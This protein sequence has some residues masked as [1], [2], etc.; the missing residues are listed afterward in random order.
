MYAK[1]CIGRSANQYSCLAYTAWVE[2]RYT[3]IG[4]TAILLSL[5]EQN[6]VRC[7]RFWALFS[8]ALGIHRDSLLIDTYSRSFFVAFT[9]SCLFE[10]SRIVVKLF[11]LKALLRY[12]LRLSYFI[13]ATLHH[14]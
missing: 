8:A 6:R 5:H 4:Q 3:G 14:M 13:I 2:T 7:V 10:I 1:Q 12:S 11:R 9:S